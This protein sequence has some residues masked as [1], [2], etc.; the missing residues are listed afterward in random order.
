MSQDLAKIQASSK[1]LLGLIN[2]ILDLS[3]IEA[4][5]MELDLET[6]EVETMVHELV[7][8]I[9]AVIR[10]NGNELEVSDRRATPAACTRT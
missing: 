10:K 5:K 8:T 2:G 4:G 9:D 6:F 1:H 3:K 7:G